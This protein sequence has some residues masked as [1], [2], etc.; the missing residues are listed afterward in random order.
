MDSIR[1]PGRSTAAERRRGVTP[2]RLL[3]RRAAGF[4]L[5][6]FLTLLLAF[7]G[8]G[9]DVVLRDEVGLAI[10]AAIGLGLGTGI[11]PRARLTPAAWMGLGGFGALA[12]LTLL[13]HTWTSSDEGTTAELARVLQY[14]GVVLLAY[15]ALN[16]YTWRGAAMGFAT[17]ALVVPLFA[18]VARLYP[19]LITDP[20]ARLG[21]DRLSYPLGYWNGISCWGAMAIAV[22]LSL[23]AN[24]AR[25]EFRAASLACVP[26][27]ALAV[28]LSYSRFG[29]VAVA[30]AVVAAL[31]VSKNRWTGAANAL[32]AGAGSAV[33]IL[34]ARGNDEIARATGNAGAESVT[35]ALIG[36]AVVCGLVAA[37]TQRAGLDRVR[38]EFRSARLA[39]GAALIGALLVAAAMNGPIGDAWE[40]FKNDKPP[41]ATGGTER[42][43]SLGSSRYDVWSTAVDA[44]ESDPLRGGGPGTFEFYWSQH[45]ETGE[46]VRDAHSLYLEEA[47]ELGLPGV[48]ALLVGLGGLLGAAIQ[49]RIGWTRRREI[50]AGSAMIASFV[51]FL[52]YAGIDWMWELGAIGTLAIGGVAAAGAGGFERAPASPLRPWARAAVVTL[53]L[54]AGAVQV[55]GL[56]ATERI[57]ASDSALAAGNF[58]RAKEL[59]DQAV[60]AE[61]WAGSPYAARA[62]ALEASGDRAGAKSATADAIDRDPDNWRNYVLLARI[63]ATRGDARAVE[64]DLG[65]VRRLAPRSPYLSAASPFRQQLAALLAA[66]AR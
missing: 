54:A 50:S 48:I 30:I 26:P 23:S 51:V 32:V 39:L 60:D 29:A 6:L 24:S 5:A 37:I 31:A 10:W 21:T 52:A 56:V 45:G 19:D 59:A 55:P 22:G 66:N 15:L 18:L 64:G 25:L 36:A 41:P 47:A 40:E 7:N 57:R 33:A 11:L 16:R 20:L 4:A 42:F 28:Y 17:A 58:A 27:A 43:T 61:P 46:F 2:R 14:S 63:D 1:E 53:A 34:V 44:F 12:G 38:M 9:Y 3:A 49:A 65:N 8:G 35:L 62:L 13:S